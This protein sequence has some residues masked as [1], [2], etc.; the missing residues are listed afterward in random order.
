MESERLKHGGKGFYPSSEER[1]L[2]EERRM[3]YI[4]VEERFE[5]AGGQGSRDF[6]GGY[7]NETVGWELISFEEKNK[8]ETLERR[9]E[10]NPDGCCIGCL[11]A[12]LGPSAIIGAYLVYEMF[13]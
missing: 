3:T 8:R 11:G 5:Q 6:G 1:K 7:A 10:T 4:P 9:N 13:K 2:A 12:I